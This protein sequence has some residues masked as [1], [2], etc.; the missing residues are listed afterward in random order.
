MIQQ[1]HASVLKVFLR[2]MY[3]T[4]IMVVKLF[5]AI[6]TGRALRM[7]IHVNGITMNILKL[8]EAGS[9]IAKA[10]ISWFSVMVTTLEI[11]SIFLGNNCRFF[12]NN[13]TLIISA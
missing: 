8:R 6:L 4:E 1:I 2:N 5:Q 3:L 11:F 9:K 13:A 10:S 7:Y 12:I